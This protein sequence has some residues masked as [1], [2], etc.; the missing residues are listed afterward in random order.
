MLRARELA[1]EHNSGYI[2][3]EHLLLALLDDSDG[4]AA[5]VLDRHGVDYQAACAAALRLFPGTPAASGQTLP[6]PLSPRTLT[7]IQAAGDLARRLNYSQIGTHHL[8]VALLRD[9]NGNAVHVVRNLGVD[10]CEIDLRVSTMFSE[11]VADSEDSIEDLHAQIDRV[12]QALKDTHRLAHSIEGLKSD[13]ASTTEKLRIR[14]LRLRLQQ[15]LKNWRSFL[16]ES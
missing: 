11:A 14:L 5:R 8:L 1:R 12:D 13:A 10:P 16:S 2:G 3:T 4:F 15:L 7:V 6:E 9:R